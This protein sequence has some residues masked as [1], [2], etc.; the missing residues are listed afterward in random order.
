MLSPQADG[1]APVSAAAAVGETIAEDPEAEAPANEVRLVSYP[2]TS[3]SPLHSPLRIVSSTCLPPPPR[4]PLHT[5]PPLSFSL[6]LSHIYRVTCVYSR[7][8]ETDRILVDSDKVR[9]M[10]WAPSPVVLHP[11]VRRYSRVDVLLYWGVDPDPRPRCGA[12]APRPG[13]GTRS[14]TVIAAVALRPLPVS[15]HFELLT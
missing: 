10:Q 3:I 5:T 8:T 4:P 9:C 7:N 2:L 15:L 1:A 13:D 14:F 12:K 11:P 6:F